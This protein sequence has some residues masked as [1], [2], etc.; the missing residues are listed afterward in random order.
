MHITPILSFFWFGA[1]AI[2]LRIGRDFKHYLEGTQ[3]KTTEVSGNGEI[4]HGLLRE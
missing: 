3:G 2:I 4:F 1:F